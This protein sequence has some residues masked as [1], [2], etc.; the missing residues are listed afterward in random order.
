M[1]T[2]AF[3]QRGY[4]SVFGPHITEFIHQKQASGVTFAHATWDLKRFDRYC[5]EKEVPKPILTQKFITHWLASIQKCPPCSKKGLF[6]VVRG[7]SIYLNSKNPES[8][9]VLTASRKSY[10]CKSILAGFIDEFMNTKY[11]QGK[12]C[13]NEDNALKSFDRYCFK[14]KLI[15]VEDV[16]PDFINDWHQY[17][18]QNI[19]S[20]EDYRYAVRGLC[21]FLKTAKGIPLEIMPTRL[22]EGHP[23][24][25]YQFESVFAE[26][27]QTFVVDKQ[28]SG[29]KYDSE[30]KMLKY[31]DLLCKDR[32]ES[33]TVLTKALVQQ[34]SVQRTTESL[35]Y[36]NK[37]VS[38][39]RQF[40]KFLISRGYKAYIAPCCPSTSSSRPHIFRN[41]ELAA[42]FTCSERYPAKNHFASLTLPVI[43][44]FYYCMG[45]RLNEAAELPRENIDLKT[46]KVKILGAKYM[47]DR[48]VYMPEDLLALARMYDLEI[49]K[50]IH[51]R[52]YFFV[53]DLLGS[54][55]IGTSLCKHFNH[56]W[57]MTG[58]A[59]T[60]DKKPT[61]HC[62][63]HTM[64]VRKLEQWYRDK[65]DYTYWLPYLSA[66]LG[67]TSLADTYH[68]IFL[69]DSSFPMIRENMKQFEN[70][71][72]QETTR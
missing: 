51:D 2:S 30:R 33:Q 26:L 3:Y 63:R 8:S 24:E 22:K 44:R 1:K 46:G 43:F 12:K 72:P 13:K 25:N 27:L 70:L 49:Q 19:A 32:K 28:A 59:E 50:N 64:V 66:Y 17:R 20:R 47:K 9:L 21:I 48:L 38:I 15:H 35:M 10:E 56:I 37:R 5:I 6:A 7:L 58:F 71:Y 11:Q 31:F 69:V 54:N 60:V 40:A 39:L 16:T 36:R 34:W 53:G 55:I 4:K 42:F 68:Y 45:L 29:Y 18:M 67:H 57:D 23:A 61:I 41:E 65:V 52:H 14:Q 62:F